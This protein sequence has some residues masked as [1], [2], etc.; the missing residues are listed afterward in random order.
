MSSAIVI[1]SALRVESLEIIIKT[2]P[3]YLNIVINVMDHKT[4][5]VPVNLHTA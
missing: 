2:W 1:I 3:M 4:I 5:Y